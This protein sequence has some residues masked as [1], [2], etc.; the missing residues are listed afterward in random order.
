[1]WSGKFDQKW[2]GPYIIDKVLGQGSYILRTLKGKLLPRPIH[3]G[4]LKKYH[5]RT[6]NTPVATIQGLLT[7][8][9]P[10]PL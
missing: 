5:E 6:M 2:I 9:E 4:R 10:F 8:Q 1:M 7:N 3:G